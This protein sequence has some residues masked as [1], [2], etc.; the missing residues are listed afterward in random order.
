LIGGLRVARAADYL[1]D[2]EIE[3]VREAQEID[4]RVDVFLKLAERRLNALLGAPAPQAPP[5]KEKKDKK[6]DKDEP[7]NDYGPEPTGTVIELL[8]NYT[9]VMSELLDKLDDVYDKKKADPKLG[10]AMEKVLDTTQSHLKRLEQVRPKL[11]SE[12]EETALEKAMEIAK[13]AIDGARD[14]KSH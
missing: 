11:K 9:K 1:N 5:P 4:K 7:S 10:K 12:A 14:F 6:K 8:D 3:R 13:M 2:Q